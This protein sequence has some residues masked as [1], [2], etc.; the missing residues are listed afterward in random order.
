MPWRSLFCTGLS[1]RCSGNVKPV[2]TV[3]S[4]CRRRIPYMRYAY[5]YKAAAHGAVPR[6]YL[7]DSCGFEGVPERS[8][9]E[10]GI[11]TLDTLRYTRFPSVRLQPLGHLSAAGWAQAAPSWEL[12]ESTIA[13]AP[14]M[15]HPHARSKVLPPKRAGNRDAAGRT[16]PPDSWRLRLS[17][18]RATGWTVASVG[19][20]PSTSRQAV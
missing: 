14:S 18:G 13:S 7:W 2:E 1:G 9:G 11:R 10:T 15:L 12:F 4:S 20:L 5:R 3:W 19:S 6:S 17:P 8:G 16:R